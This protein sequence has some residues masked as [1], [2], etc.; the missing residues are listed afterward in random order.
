MKYIETCYELQSCI[1]M[2]LQK[3]NMLALSSS[4]STATT[5]TATTTLSTTSNN[6]NNNKNKIDQNEYNILLNEINNIF[7]SSYL[8][9]ISDDY[10]QQINQLKEYRNLIKN[11]INDVNM[12]EKYNTLI[13]NKEKQQ[14]M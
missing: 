13:N 4:S 3:L 1:D 5:T 9:N 11:K 10:N 6:N 7:F 14:E 2:M 8:S 12:K